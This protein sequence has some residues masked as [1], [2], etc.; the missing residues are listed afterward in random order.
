MKNKAYD[1]ILSFPGPI[2]GLVHSIAGLETLLT[3]TVSFVLR[4]QISGA[5][6]Q[7]WYIRESLIIGSF[8]AF[9]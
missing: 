4:D 2:Q 8:I 7:L 3:S 6:D 9:C 1:W 5:W